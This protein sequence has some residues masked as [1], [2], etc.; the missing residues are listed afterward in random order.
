VLAADDGAVGLGVAMLLLPTNPVRQVDRALH[1]VVD[2]LAQVLRD[3]ADA[4]ER[5]DDALALDALARA[6]GLQV[7]VDQL[8]DASRHTAD[9]ALLA[10]ARWGS[11]PALVAVE[12][13]VP[14][15]DNAAR[16]GRVLARQAVTAIRRQDVPPPG[17][18]A[19]LRQTATA[20]TR[21]ADMLGERWPDRA[22]LAAAEA[23]EQATDVLHHTA[24]LFSQVVVAQARAVAADVLYAT[25]LR[26]EEV[27]AFL[28]DVP[29]PRPTS[30]RDEVDDTD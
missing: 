21:L 5:G 15:L 20:V 28:P 10:P 9:V 18:P 24:G 12:A 6:R 29:E 2:P 16:N 1:G 4:L 17:L 8:R 30:R 19:A 14:H 25:G 27:V 11:R 22:R 13:A 26:Y 23:A 3:T 7:K